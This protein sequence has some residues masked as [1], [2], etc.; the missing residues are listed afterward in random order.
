MGFLISVFIFIAFLATGAYVSSR[1]GR[2]NQPIAKAPEAK[3]NALANS[4][5]V[6]GYWTENNSKIEAVDLSSGKIYGLASLSKDIKKVTIL[7]P[8]NLIFINKTNDKDHG[9]DISSYSLPSKQTTQ[10]I[11]ADEGFGIDDYTVSPNKRYIAVWEIK[12]SKDSQQ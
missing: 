12:V 3:F 7:T 8:D 4:S 11:K 1:I 2:P 10:L 6:Y 5:I 9:Q